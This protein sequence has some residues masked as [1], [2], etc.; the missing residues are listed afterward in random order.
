MKALII[1]QLFVWMLPGCSDPDSTNFGLYPGEAELTIDGVNYAATAILGTRTLG[2]TEY[3]QISLIASDTVL[4]DILNENFQ[5]GR[6]EWTGE[7]FNAA[8]TMVF[9]H[10]PGLGFGFGPESGFL[11]ISDRTTTT[12]SGIFNLELQDFA[13]SCSNCPQDRVWVEAKFWAMR[14]EPVSRGKP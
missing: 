2:D 11:I 4:V 9:M 5:E 14:D 6:V 3:E 1:L 8:G 12:I 13:S 10:H 7:T